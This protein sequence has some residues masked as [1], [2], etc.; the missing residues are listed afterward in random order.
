MG[1]IF[2]VYNLVRFPCQFFELGCLE[3]HTPRQK[4]DHEHFCPHRPLHC[5]FE[6]YGCPVVLPLKDIQNHIRQCQFNTSRTS[7]VQNS[8]SKLQ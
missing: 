8:T 3:Y 7:A 4:I 6:A 2:Q 1:F 5:H